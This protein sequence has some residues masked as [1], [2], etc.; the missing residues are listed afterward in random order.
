[1]QSRRA[2]VQLAAG[3]AGPSAD[4]IPTSM[5]GTA[6]SQVFGMNGLSHEDMMH[7]DW[8]ARLSLSSAEQFQIDIPSDL[9]PYWVH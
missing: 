5:N 1:L 7:M 4:G 9:V 3:R 2:G 8:R 6:A